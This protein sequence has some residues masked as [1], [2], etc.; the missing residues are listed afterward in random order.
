[1]DY[2]IPSCVSDTQLSI[3]SFYL[4]KNTEGKSVILCQFQQTTD[5]L[6]VRILCQGS[7]VLCSTCYSFKTNGTGGKKKTQTNQDTP[8]FQVYYHQAT[9]LEIF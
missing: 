5:S 2:S 1:M 6:A 4:L 3:I 9:W 8:P 7:K